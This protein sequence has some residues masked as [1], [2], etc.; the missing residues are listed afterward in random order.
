[1]EFPLDFPRASTSHWTDN[2][3]I[4]D[5]ENDH[6]FE[7]SEKL[8][9]R[10]T[11]NQRWSSRSWIWL[12]GINALILCLTILIVTFGQQTITNTDTIKKTQGYSKPQGLTTVFRDSHT[13]GP[14]FKTFSPTLTPTILNGSLFNYPPS[15]FRSDPTPALDAESSRL[16][17]GGWILITRSDVLSLG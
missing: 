6:L 2:L 14:F 1:M 10:R 3:S 11:Q 5:L 9:L 4:E 15:L 12:T 17:D 16:T 8:G 13:T 7:K